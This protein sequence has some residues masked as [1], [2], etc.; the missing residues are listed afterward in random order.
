LRPESPLSEK[1]EGGK[2]R[3]YPQR[4]IEGTTIGDRVE[5]AP[6][7]DDLASS[8]IAQISPEVGVGVLHDLELPG[9]CLV[10]EPSPKSRILG[11]PSE[12]PITTPG[13][14]P[15]RCQL[16]E[17]VVDAHAGRLERREA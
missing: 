7:G 17:K 5:M 4:P 11:C 3:R 9:L 2:R 16:G 15:D 12:P 8:R 10:E 13:G 14:E 1:V 6:Y